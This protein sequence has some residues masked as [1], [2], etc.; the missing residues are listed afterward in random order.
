M[1]KG[2]H[3]FKL[4]LHLH[5]SIYSQEPA[6]ARF[7]VHYQT[8]QQ[9]HEQQDQEQGQE[10]EPAEQS[11]KQEGFVDVRIC[12]Y[13]LTKTHQMILALRQADKHEF[14]TRFPVVFNQLIHV[15]CRNKDARAREEAFKTFIFLLRQYVHYQS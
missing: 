10:A 3:V 15:I 13:F 9:E 2:A 11:D 4:R 7:S 1:D 12:C 14:V 5:S 8:E 6:L